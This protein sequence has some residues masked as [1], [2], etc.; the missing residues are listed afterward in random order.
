MARALVHDPHNL[1]LDEPGNGLD[2][3]SLRILR[4][5]LVD[6]RSEGRCVVLSTHAMHDVSQL[7][8]QVAILAGGKLIALG[9]P[10][11]LQRRVRQDSLEDAFVSL[12][13]AACAS[14]RPESALP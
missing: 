3:A 6:I 4:D 7:C 2:V 14:N 1:L 10:A 11:E 5:V 13:Q 8:D 9:T 12:V